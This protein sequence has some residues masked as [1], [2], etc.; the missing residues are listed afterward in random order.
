[1]RLFVVEPILVLNDSRRGVCVHE[2]ELCRDMFISSEIDMCIAR[3][4]VCHIRFSLQPL[5]NGKALF[6]A[7][8]TLFTL[9]GPMGFLFRLSE[10]QSE[11]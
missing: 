11:R 1:M 9:H 10:Q 3:S 7:D 2:G 4:L 8:H 5:A 6:T